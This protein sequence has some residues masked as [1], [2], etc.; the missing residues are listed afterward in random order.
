MTHITLKS[1]YRKQ[2]FDGVPRTASI[3]NIVSISLLPGKSGLS[4][5]NSAIMQPTAHTSIGEL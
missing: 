5:Y 4:M 2:T 1:N 3:L